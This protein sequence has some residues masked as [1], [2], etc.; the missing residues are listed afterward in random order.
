[1]C[2]QAGHYNSRSYDQCLHPTSRRTA[3]DGF[4]ANQLGGSARADGQGNEPGGR[5]VHVGL[6]VNW[7]ALVWRG[8]RLQQKNAILLGVLSSVGLSA[9]HSTAA[10]PRL[11]KSNLRACSQAF[12]SS[13]RR[14]Q[15]PSQQLFLPYAPPASA[16]IERNLA[17]LHT[18]PITPNSSTLFFFFLLATTP[19]KLLTCMPLTYLHCTSAVDPFPQRRKGGVVICDRQNDN[20]AHLQACRLGSSQARTE[21]SSTHWNLGFFGRKHLA[22]TVRDRNRAGVELENLRFRSHQPDAERVHGKYMQ[23]NYSLMEMIFSF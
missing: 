11:S 15:H 3:P 21:S 7:L 9:K 20:S 16:H 17:L 19:S 12:H 6:Q 14:L 2:G 1:M 23:E 22:E 4:Q 8:G 10:A 5:R 18:R 13:R